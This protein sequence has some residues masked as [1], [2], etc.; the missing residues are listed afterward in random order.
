MNAI[1]FLLRNKNRKNH[2]NFQSL[3]LFTLYRVAHL[4]IPTN[5]SIPSDFLHQSHI[6]EKLGSRFIVRNI[7]EVESFDNVAQSDEFS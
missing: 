5:L 6:N 1:R 2:Y 4:I 3:P 7:L